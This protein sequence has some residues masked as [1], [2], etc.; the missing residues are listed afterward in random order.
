MVAAPRKIR[1]SPRGRNVYS[2]AIQFKDFVSPVGAAG[3]VGPGMALRWSW[4]GLGFVSHAPYQHS[5]IIDPAP[6]MSE[7]NRDVIAG[8]LH[9]VLGTSWPSQLRLRDIMSHSN[10]RSKVQAATRTGEASPLTRLLIGAGA[11][12][13]SDCDSG[14][15]GPSERRTGLIPPHICSLMRSARSMPQIG[16]APVAPL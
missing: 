13:V 11:V 12:G 8:S 3:I 1:P 4:I 16:T 5:G 6:V 10:S 7:C 2:R 15:A 9:P 14:G